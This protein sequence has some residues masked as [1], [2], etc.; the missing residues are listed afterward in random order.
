MFAEAEVL[1]AFSDSPL[2]LGS[3]CGWEVEGCRSGLD[4]TQSLQRHHLLLELE[5]CCGSET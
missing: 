2:A 3:Y 1:F 5:Q 4:G